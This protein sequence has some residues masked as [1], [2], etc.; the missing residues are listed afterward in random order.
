[1]NQNTDNTSSKPPKKSGRSTSPR[2]VEARRLQNRLAQRNHRRRLR[3]SNQESESIPQDAENES[4]SSDG[5]PHHHQPT[6]SRSES[7]LSLEHHP[8]LIP[9]Y[10]LAE[11]IPGGPQSISGTSTSAISLLAHDSQGTDDLSLQQMNAN[12]AQSQSTFMAHNCGCNGITGPCA[13]HVE[14]IW[15]QS[16]VSTSSSSQGQNFSRPPSRP[17][18]PKSSN[19]SSP[20]FP[21][22]GSG[23]LDNVALH[24]TFINEFST[25]IANSA[26]STNDLWSN[27]KN[28]PAVTEETRRFEMVLEMVRTAGFQ[29]LESMMGAY[30]TSQF[31]QD[32][33]PAMAQSTSRSRRLKSLLKEISDSSTSWPR[34]QSRGFYEVVANMTASICTDEMDQIGGSNPYMSHPT[35]SHDDL[36]RMIIALERLVKDTEAHKLHHHKQMGVMEAIPDTMPHLWALLTETAGGSSVYCERI[37]KAVLLILLH[38]RNAE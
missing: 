38:A 8:P 9:D 5:H 18:P 15:A 20:P 32:S 22:T 25:N 19:E 37:I 1:M 13:A 16:S 11:S 36:R 3:E 2:A 7:D 17:D 33:L 30:Y 14:M 28:T 21:H 29:D 24:P 10:S 31:E 4:M 34:W 12:M 23:N 6:H 27:T 35:T 26:V